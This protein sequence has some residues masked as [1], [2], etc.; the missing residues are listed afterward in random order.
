[1]PPRHRAGGL[2]RALR[3]LAAILGEIRQQ[4]AHRGIVGGIENET[5][6]L[7]PADQPDPAQV[8]KME[9]ER[10]R[11][12]SQ[13]LADQAGVEAFWTGLDEQTKQDKT[14]R[15][16]QSGELVAG[17]IMF[18]VSSIVEMIGHVKCR[19]ARASIRIARR[20]HNGAAVDLA[21]KAGGFGLLD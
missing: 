17:G 14:R 10:R 8:G 6:V 4:L 9:R 20:W 21:R 5:T 16:S 15:V 19:T 12:Q 7:P 3:A 1:M 13:L 18:H 2:G 11:R